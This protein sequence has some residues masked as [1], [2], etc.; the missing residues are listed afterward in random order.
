MIYTADTE[1][2]GKRRLWSFPDQ[3]EAI[4]FG[5]DMGLTIADAQPLTSWFNFLI[6]AEQQAAAIA[7]GAKRVAFIAPS[8]QQAVLRGDLSMV[9]SVERNHPEAELV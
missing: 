8:Y 7:K 4:L 1:W 9:R 3:D 6:T 5:Y 2:Q